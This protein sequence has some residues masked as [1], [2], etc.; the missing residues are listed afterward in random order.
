[1]KAITDTNPTHE[2]SIL[3][4][5]AKKIWG[6][7]FASGTILWLIGL[8]LWQQHRIDESILFE[9]Q[10]LRGA[11]GPLILLSQ[12]LTSYGMA[13]I[14]SIFVIYLLASQKL[15]ALDAPLTY[16]FYTI[17]SL[18]LSGIAGDLLK[19]VLARPRPAIAFGNQ[20]LA[21]SQSIT[22]AMPSGHATKSIAL[23]LPFLLLVP[24]SNQIHRVI[25][26]IIVLLAAGVCFSRIVLA[27]HYMSDVVAGIGMAVIGF[28]LTMMFANM[29]FQQTKA[30]QLPLLSKLW[31]ILLIF[32]TALF[33]NM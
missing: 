5:D 18:G 4:P 28:P 15:K 10:T 32:L 8:I 13:V 11:Q 14:A 9:Y 6:I 24:N 12:W 31:G 33:M 17:C 20:I 19:E 21:L 16:Y 26:V 3:L 25:K 1:M 7:C 22:P 29:I 23:I 30:E 2:T 27:A